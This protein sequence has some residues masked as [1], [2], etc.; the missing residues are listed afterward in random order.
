L[1]DSKPSKGY[2]EKENYQPSTEATRMIKVLCFRRLF[3]F[4]LIHIIVI[5]MGISAFAQEEI[6]VLV[7]SSDRLLQ[8]L[9]VVEEKLDN[10][11]LSAPADSSIPMLV[12]VRNS[13]CKEL[14]KRGDWPELRAQAEAKKNG[15]T[16]T[17]LHPIPQCRIRFIGKQDFNRMSESKKLMIEFQ[18]ERYR[19]F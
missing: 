17:V 4:I 11:K 10:L 5:G 3:S 16:V 14:I 15:E 7:D 2:E 6:P 12:Q 9:L 13:A 19:I 18:P 1:E 8:R